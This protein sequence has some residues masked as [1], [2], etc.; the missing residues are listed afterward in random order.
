MWWLN[1]IQVRSEAA[2]PLTHTVAAPQLNG[3]SCCY[4]VPSDRT[5]EAYCTSQYTEL[6]S[7]QILIVMSEESKVFF[8]DSVFSSYV[9]NQW[10]FSRENAHQRRKPWV[11]LGQVTWSVGTPGLIHIE[12]QRDVHVSAG[13]ELAQGEH[14]VLYIPPFVSVCHRAASLSAVSKSTQHQ[15]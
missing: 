1:L 3:P 8:L 9:E 15:Q 7:N 5:A 14:I 10:F 13:C 6:G 2:L 12:R 4:S 11:F